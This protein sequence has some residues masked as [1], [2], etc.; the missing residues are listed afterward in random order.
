MR[1]LKLPFLLMIFIAFQS[2]TKEML[3]N[4]LT[5]TWKVIEAYEEGEDITS[6]FH[7]LLPNYRVTFY[8][9]GDFLEVAYPF[10][11]KQQTSG[12]WE[13]RNNQ[14]RL[15]LEDP[16]GTRNFVL[17]KL[18]SKRLEIELESQKQYFHLI[19]E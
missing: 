8:D 11:V 16:N 4:R 1:S 15:F 3:E 5:Q 18:N 6:E 12:K 9:N 14:K 17:H 7:I 2:C 19:P 10:G 13:F